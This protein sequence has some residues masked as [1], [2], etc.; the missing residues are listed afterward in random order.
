MVFQYTQRHVN[1]ISSDG[2]IQLWRSLG[3]EVSP[4]WAIES[5]KAGGVSEGR[6]GVL[7]FKS[8]GDHCNG[9]RSQALPLFLWN[10]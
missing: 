3:K 5:A 8:R 7:L 10:N 9:E 1:H 2:H 6:K 4:L